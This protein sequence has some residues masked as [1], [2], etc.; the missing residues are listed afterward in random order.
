M[1]K[2]QK[3]QK[4]GGLKSNVTIS[5]LKNLYGGAQNRDDSRGK[6][7]K[8]TKKPYNGALWGGPYLSRRIPPG[9]VGQNAMYTKGL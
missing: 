8:M 7:K 9:T 1:A 4:R 3:S 5:L 2:S 6:V